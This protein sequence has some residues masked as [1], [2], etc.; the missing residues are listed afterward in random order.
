MTTLTERQIQ[1]LKAMIEEYIETAEPV[2]SETLDKKY[3]MGISP[4]TIRN[5]MAQLKKNGYLKQPHTSAGRVPTPKALRFYVESLLK[6]KHL[7]VA[8]EVK[9]KQ[10]VW[11][12]R[13]QMDKLLREATRALA[14]QTRTL[15]LAATDE[16]DLFAS[17]LGNILEM[18]EFYDINITKHLLDSLDEYD[19]WWKIFSDIYQGS[20]PLEVLLGKD[21]RSE[22]LNPCGGVFARFSSA[23]HKGVI[24]VVGPYRLKYSEVIPAVEY[25]SN[26]I[27]ELARNW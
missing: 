13:N 14:M 5:E 15:S 7:S 9:V 20:Q 22:F 4:A 6:L 18:P 27:N 12:F 1:I 10:K 3:N 25:I 17:G 26:L 24:G 8:E 23:S 21:L 2:G 16:G 11:E 19:F